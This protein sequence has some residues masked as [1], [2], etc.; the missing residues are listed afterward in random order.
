[1]MN[2]FDESVHGSTM[3]FRR[4]MT[5]KN[6]QSLHGSAMASHPYVL[7]P[8]FPQSYKPSLSGI[9]RKLLETG[10]YAP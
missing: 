6:E 3:Y 8:Y 2:C 9:R 10:A 4:G 5:Q 7:P 1:M